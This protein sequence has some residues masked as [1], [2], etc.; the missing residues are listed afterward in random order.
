MAGLETG[1]LWSVGAPGA[2]PRQFADAWP[3]AGSGPVTHRAGIDDP[4]RSWPAFQPG[5]LD[6]ATGAREHSCTVVF[7]L[8][9]S[10]A[11]GAVLHLAFWASHGPCP[12]IEINV[13]GRV[14]RYLPVVRRADRSEVFRQSPI[15]GTVRLA[16]GLPGAWC[17]P[18]G[19][20]LTVTTVLDAGADPDGPP[21]PGLDTEG[22][23]GAFHRAY[24]SWFGSGITWDSLRLT[25]EDPAS[26]HD[27]PGVRVRTLPLRRRSGSG[28]EQLVEVVVDQPPGAA[29][30]GP[31]RLEIEGRPPREVA[32]RRGARAFGQSRT[33]LG[34]VPLDG[35]TSGVLTMAG[36]AHPVELQPT[37]RWTLHLI[38]HVHLDVGFTDHQA[39]VLELH[40]RNL[41]RVVTAVGSDPDVAYSV[42]GALVVR[43]YLATR[44][45]RSVATVLDLLRDG[46][47]A[48]NAF[49]SL[50]LSG[51][52][53]LE[54]CYRSADLA[55]GLRA[56]YGVPVTYANLTDVPSYSAALPG[57]LTQ[58]GLDAFVGIENHG[59]AATADSDLAHLLSPVRWQGLDGAEVLA[60]FT[61]SY[62]QLRFLAGDPQTLAGAAQA[63]VRFLDR[64]ERPDYLPTD[65]PLIGTH[66]DN[67]D[68]GDGDTAF[69]G[70]WNAAYSSP[71]LVVSTLAGFLDTIRPLRDRLPVWR[72]DG[73]SFWEDGAGTA[74]SLI[75]RH[76]A[77]QQL[78]P[79]AETFGSL[80][81]V[82]PGAPPTRPD[83]TALDTGWDALLSGS[84]HTWTWSHALAHPHGEMGH[85]QLAWKRHRVETAYRIGLDELRRSLSQLGEA[86]TTDGQTVLVA[87][88]LSWTRD[89]DVEIELTARSVLSGTGGP[90][91]HEVLASADGLERRRYTV[92]SVPAFGYR[93]L[94]ESAAA[95][96]APGGAAVQ[97]VPVPAED[98]QPG[99]VSSHL[100]TTRWSA[101]VDPGTGQ[102]RSLHHRLSGRE[103]LDASSPW[104]LGTV[105]Y[106][107]GPGDSTNRG[108]GPAASTL[109]D[110]RPLFPPPDIRLT[111]VAMHPSSA[112]RTHDGLRV[113][114]EGAGPGVA[115]VRL[116]V[117]LRDGSDRV[118][119]VVDLDKEAVLAKEAVYVVFPFRCGTDDTVAPNL[120]YDRQAGWVDPG[121]DHTPGA[122]NEWFTT[123][124]AVVVRRAEA[125]V[126]WSSADA[127][128]FT[129]DDIVRGRWPET[130]SMS[131]TTV[132]SWV[133]NNYWPTNTPPSQAG[134]LRLRYA[135]RPA[136]GFDPAAATRLGRELRAPAASSTVTWLDKADTAPRP[137]PA[138]SGTLVDLDA[139][140]AVAVTIA[141]TA[142]EGQLLLR[143]QELTGTGR[144]VR[145]RS[146]VG[147]AGGVRSCLADRRPTGP[148][149][150]TDGRWP[151]ELPGWAVRS[152]LLDREDTR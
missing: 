146:P 145:L 108:G 35:P 57:V 42:D 93:V 21:G 46:H 24:G 27:I 118:D 85:D 109:T 40:S 69:V 90:L 139:P 73:G 134:R 58:L 5:P 114:A 92:P 123:H 131:T 104:H 88:Q 149:V 14:G 50:F 148:V 39:K 83:R 54:E 15:A 79:A 137:L 132:L 117:L 13:D 23:A 150:V 47:L 56:R 106:A 38:P 49:A 44:P 41:D 45:A 141:G 11:R 72:G 103:M 115:S 43:E 9:R 151:V 19:H 81:S 8:A 75:A 60:W 32:A 25:D 12:E 76:R 116:E 67:E 61:D 127:P 142:V 62:S 86:V 138:G 133:M 130:F 121:V 110:R 64:Y 128:L 135:F 59:R 63:F 70:R 105:L 102:L 1:V 143:V 31:V 36:S 97:Q 147:L 37:R 66:A 33:V 101:V 99:L 100:Q 55:A 53:G 152:F 22:P 26:G 140:A 68:L 28:E 120:H 34:T 89:I 3:A 29:D 80:L 65:L 16:V 87:N 84:E 113:T 144:T 2:G 18:G 111:A 107:G 30:P 98:A 82:V 126:E 4:S 129:V 112:R 6:V 95:D 52:A 78:L 94:S 96:V 10:P 51:L 74:A 7:D 125:A 124:D 71:R 136:D 20:R 91:S 77:A 48:V 17:T 122:C 119:V